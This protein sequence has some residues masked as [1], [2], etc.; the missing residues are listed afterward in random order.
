[1][2]IIANQFENQ[3]KPSFDE[4]KNITDSKKQCLIQA[5]TFKGSELFYKKLSYS[6]KGKI[7]S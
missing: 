5:Y 6:S 3:N 2:F 7:M 4:F 1:M